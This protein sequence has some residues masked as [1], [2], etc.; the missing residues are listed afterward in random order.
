MKTKS[1]FILAILLFACM[2]GAAAYEVGYRTF[3]DSEE[4]AGDYLTGV[5]VVK[6]DAMF[7]PI[8]RE[9]GTH[10]AIGYLKSED[11]A[12]HIS[13][14]SSIDICY[15]IVTKVYRDEEGN[16]SYDWRYETV[17]YTVTQVHC[18][19]PEIT[20]V[21][22]PNTVESLRV[23]RGGKLKTVNAPSVKYIERETF[24]H[25]P[26]LETVTLNDAVKYI[27][28]E[29]FA[30][31]PKLKNIEG[32]T[33]VD[34]IAKKAFLLSPSLETI[35]G[36]LKVRR[37]GREAFKDCA[38]L[39]TA[40]TELKH[41]EE[42][43]FAG[44]ASIP[45]ADV[46]KAEYIENAA[47]ARCS[48][49]ESDLFIIAEDVGDYAFSR[50]SS[51][52]KV[53]INN[54][55]K[56][57]GAKAFLE[58]GNM[59]ELT[60]GEN[61]ELEIGVAAFMGCCG[62]T[63]VTIRGKIIGEEAFSTVGFDTLY[64]SS[65]K[66]L[67]IDHSVK[68]I[69]DEAFYKC[70]SLETLNLGDSVETIGFAAFS[71]AHNLKDTL[72]F[73]PSVKHIGFAAFRECGIKYLELSPSLE[74]I[75]GSTFY[76][77]QNLKKVEI[78]KNVKIIGRWAFAR[79]PQVAQVTMIA[80]DS[81]DDSAFREC[82]EL[83]SITLGDS[84]RFLGNYA[85]HE[86]TKI[87]GHIKFPKP[88]EY[89]GWKNFSGCR[90][91]TGIDL[92]DGLK[93]IGWEAFRECFGIT[94]LTLPGKLEA[95]GDGAFYNC[96]NIESKLVFPA[97]MKAI[98]DRAFHNCEKLQ[99]IDL[100]RASELASI[101]AK[102]FYSCTGLTG[103]LW[104]PDAVTTVGIEAFYYCSGINSLYIG[105]SLKEVGRDA[106]TSFPRGNLTSI[107][108]NQNNPNYDSRKDCNAMI[109]TDT[110]TLYKGCCHTVIP[111]TVTAIGNNAFQGC[112]IIGEINI[113]DAVT[114]I[115]DDAFYAC[116]DITRI[117]LSE[118]NK[119]A[120]IGEEAFAHCYRLREIPQL[121][122]IVTIGEQAFEACHSMPGVIF[123]SQ[124]KEIGRAAF[125]AC[126]IQHA[127]FKSA[128]PPTVGERA[129]IY[130]PEY[131]PYMFIPCNRTAA[132]QAAMPEQEKFIESDTY[133]VS[134]VSND[135]E[136]GKV[137]YKSHDLCE[138]NTVTVTAIPEPGF[139]FLNWTGGI[140]QNP[141][142]FSATSDLFLVAYFEADPEQ[143]YTITALSND[144][145]QGTVT[146]GGLYLE[147]ATATLTAV[148]KEGY[149]F[150]KW[151]DENTDNPRSIVV[152]SDATF[153]AFFDVADGIDGDFADGVQIYSVNK[154]IVIGNAENSS[155]SI[156]NS[157]GQLLINEAAIA[158]NKFVI[159]VEHQGIYFVKVGKNKVQRVLIK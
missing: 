148:P 153:T 44:C 125:N 51:I 100:K 83:T 152:T 131:S 124:L 141:C 71:E 103:E 128:T 90:K 104:I 24:R 115:G 108:V 6:G 98:G 116:H 27:G 93:G 10:V 30:F 43:A 55:V 70:K 4:L 76:G 75:E 72:T 154:T 41:I 16:Y 15:K 96:W 138:S 40:F 58:C 21:T 73:P 60:F 135:V 123:G 95:V 18:S 66:N 113:P 146:G 136:M 7:H 155:V 33:S 99:G 127:T 110:N 56:K 85:F 109:E 129:F 20:S 1:I 87:E 11:V 23:V 63:D 158:T 80:V 106:F 159:S 59:E 112:D 78:P 46:S 137:S 149:Q 47:F 120:S 37:V 12:G 31:C 53:H 54:T 122:S 2:G 65:L 107:T 36:T 91:I 35:A 79:C 42:S 126:A 88:L 94:K 144:S 34:S 114:S 81:I 5:C 92:P 101:G 157:T 142:T 105:A 74:I 82:E 67:T 45:A 69:K 57:I 29:A 8:D 68:T 25:N 38:K 84:L 26:E 77:C 64:N 32:V 17:T 117:N 151:Q 19:G 139:R 97:T 48:S 134:V 119:L 14:P 130:D 156:Y 147:N 102:A 28:E 89:I 145:T 52:P 143:E 3:D 62:L 22:I 49:I 111:E 9:D 50:C 121:Y 13:F 118:N 132:Y 61:D 86:C 39:R 150:L 140:S 133:N